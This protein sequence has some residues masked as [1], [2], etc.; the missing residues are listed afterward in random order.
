MRTE[1]V[2]IEVNFLFRK[3]SERRFLG[4]FQNFFKFFLGQK[5]DAH[6]GLKKLSDDKT[7]KPLWRLGLRRFHEV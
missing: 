5:S 4:K 6:H 3:S 1:V 7:I 2:D